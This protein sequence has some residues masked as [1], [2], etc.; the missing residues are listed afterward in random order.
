MMGI[1]SWLFGDRASA[2][3]APSPTPEGHGTE[4]EA[5][6][7]FDLDTVRPFLQRVRDKR[8]VDF[9]V[10]ALTQYA[11]QTEIDTERRMRLTVG[12]EGRQ[13][14]L[15]YGVFMDDIDSPDLYF[16]SADKALI[17]AINAEYDL[18]AEDLGI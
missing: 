10:D 14:A 5:S 17:D 8:G 12:F 4:Y 2:Q 18:F 9:D 16:F 3:P 11:E 15:R 7:N 13:S 6:M 1:F